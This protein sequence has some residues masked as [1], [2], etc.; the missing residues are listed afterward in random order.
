LRFLRKV[1]HA[2]KFFTRLFHAKHRY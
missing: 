1:I 2:L